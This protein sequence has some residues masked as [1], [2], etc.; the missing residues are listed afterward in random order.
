M[1]T[2]TAL[3]LLPRSLRLMWTHWE[4]FVGFVY[5][6]VLFILSVPE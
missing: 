6:L 1:V 4:S 5:G 2:A 3:P